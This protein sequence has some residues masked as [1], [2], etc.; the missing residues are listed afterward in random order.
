MKVRIVY[1]KYHILNNFKNN[2]FAVEYLCFIE[3]ILGN[4]DHLL[5]YFQVVRRGLGFILWDD[6]SY[7]YVSFALQISRS[8]LSDC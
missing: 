6:T 8:S 7:L 1:L 2:S 5:Y 3:L 4:W